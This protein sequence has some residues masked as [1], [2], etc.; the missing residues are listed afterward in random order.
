MSEKKEE[1]GLDMEQI[2]DKCLERTGFKT[3]LKLVPNGTGEESDENLDKM[4][5][6]LGLKR[7]KIVAVISSKDLFKNQ[8]EE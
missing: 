4:L 3:I 1:D 2:L 7:G 5:A 8:E 6:E